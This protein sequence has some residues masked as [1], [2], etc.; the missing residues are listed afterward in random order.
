MPTPTEPTRRAFS[1][2][3]AGMAF[4]ADYNPEQWAP[5]VWREDVRLMVE[6]GVTMVTLG[7]FSWGSI[8]TADGVYD[9]AGL[10]EVV[11]LLHGAGI[12]IDLA[13]PTAS[14][15]IW[16]QQL[17]PEIVPTSREG[18]HY[19]QGG[20][21]GWCP[22][23]DV[24]RAFA[25]R[26]VG[27]LADRYGDHPAVRMWHVSN[28]LGGGNRHCYCDASAA[29]FRR[30]LAERHGTIERL[31]QAWG[32]AFWGHRY[33]GFDEVLPPRDSESA[34]NPG[35]VLDFDR[36]SSD[37][38]LEH[39]LAERDLI[40]QAAPQ[41]PVTTNFMVA[42][43]P[44]VV[45]YARWAPHMDVLAND[46]Y[47]LADDPQREEELAFSADRMRGLDTSRPWMLME[48]STS[49]VNWQ[50]VN[51]SKDPGELLR[52][53]LAH[54]ARGADGVMFFQWRA[55]TAGA[56]QFHSAMLPHAG[57]RTKVFREVRELGALLGNL[58]EVVGSL[59]E[60]SRV[61]ILFDDEA[62]WAWRSGE[63]PHHDLHPSHAAREY[64]RALFNRGITADI[65]APWTDLSRYDLVIVPAL[66]LTSDADAAAVA[67]AAH[68]GAVVA[69]TY[70]S[71]IVDETN[72]VR[73]G[74]YPGAYRELLGVFGEEFFTLQDGESIELDSGWPATTWSESVE[75]VASEVVA[76]YATGQLAG[77]PAI[78]RR[79][80]GGGEAWYVSTRLGQSGVDALVARLLDAAGI[81]PTVPTAPGLEAVRRVAGGRSWLFLLNHSAVELAVAVDGTD[82]A[83]GRTLAGET[84]IPARGVLV[85]RER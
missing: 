50:R 2:P 24:W 26:I 68:A 15:P 21:L 16:L 39:Y 81:A 80:V 27:V 20:R 35:L 3:L 9:F 64:H 18:V 14:P 37:A 74:G 51:R 29:H 40:R 13:T 54:V 7:V 8:E 6:A 4:G 84:A 60:P 46:H 55:S 23:S 33:G 72:R 44:D 57:E 28:E 61:A 70:L 45:D 38:L 17:H 48:H 56:E 77:S 63:K 11:E 59:V 47:S 75:A 71:G 41:H 25:L 10:D 69:V 1:W 32:T 12:A 79:V 31:N 66:F 73:A 62:G 49:A 19:S 42:Q 83:T 82:L 67:A 5:E 65:V 53:S 43:G 30:W 76:S 36:F 58:S 22:S 34:P 85:V 52:N 78:T